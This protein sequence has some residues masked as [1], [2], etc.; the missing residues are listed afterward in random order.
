MSVRKNGI[1][2]SIMKSPGIVI[3]L[4]TV[5]CAFGVYG[6]I[7]MNKQEFPEFSIRLG[8]V[9]GVYPGANAQQVEEQLTA[10]LEDYLFSYEEVD[11][12]G[13]EKAGKEARVEEESAPEAA[14]SAE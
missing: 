1:V 4:V 9:A 7:N 10:P 6:L 12:K 5:L 3:L 8:V 2:E 14:D 11:K 13:A